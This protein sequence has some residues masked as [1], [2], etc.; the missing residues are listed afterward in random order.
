MDQEVEKAGLSII[1]AGGLEVRDVDAG[2]SPFL[3]T[4][5]NWGPGYVQIKGLVGQRKVLKSLVRQLAHKVA[6]LHGK[7]FDFIEGNA[8]GGMIPGWQ[9]CDYV[10]QELGL[11]EGDIPYCYLRGSRKVAG[12]GELITGD[13]NNP[14]IR[15]GMRALVVE[16]MVNFAQTT[17]NAAIEYREA[18]YPVT[19]AA[20]IMPY[21]H[22]HANELLKK[23]GVTLISVITLPQLLDVAEGTDI[24]QAGIN[25]YREFLRDPIKWQ[26]DKNLPIPDS[27]LEK[28]REKGY[29][30]RS[31]TNPE[32]VE[33]GVP[34]EKLDE[35]IKYWAKE[36]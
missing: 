8:T 5:G 25:T 15:K 4:T 29:K 18:G 3:Y 27:S 30:M 24:S 14:E 31:L 22:S 21:D 16:E 2:E 23:T 34:R 10:E 11:E 33:V 1:S 26:L 32:A 9:L 20:T 19:Y 35:G 6:P 36:A 17:T 13:R 28:A 12:H 7:A